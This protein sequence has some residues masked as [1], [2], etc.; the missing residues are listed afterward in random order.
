[1]LCEFYP[2]SILKGSKGKQYTYF[3]HGS[4]YS[5]RAF[6]YMLPNACFLM[7][8]VHSSLLNECLPAN[9]PH[10]SPPTKCFSLCLPHTLPASGSRRGK[11]GTTD[12]SK[13][14]HLSVSCKHHKR[15]RDC[16]TQP[17]FDEVLIFLSRTTFL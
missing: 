9:A 16:N 13:N 4:S 8:T 17:A 3:C 7:H 6:H 1:M 15:I 10:Q 14:T 12:S 11:A 5:I 2:K